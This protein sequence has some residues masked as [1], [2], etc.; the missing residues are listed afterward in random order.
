MT[1]PQIFSA[2]AGSGLC[3][4][5]AYVFMRQKTRRFKALFWFAVGIAMVYAAF[6]PQIIEVMGEDSTELRLR[7][8]VALLSFAAVT[9]T[10]EAVRISRMEERFAFLWLVTAALLFAGAL[11]EDLAHLVSRITGMSYGA[12]VMVVLFTFTMFM[13]FHVSL[14]LSRLQARLSQVARQLA[15][16]EERLRMLEES[17]ADDA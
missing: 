10:L 11:S 14:A 5:S 3:L 15:L 17:H 13:L 6:R 9:V 7:L 8:V 2:V 4:A 12:V 1:V 16:T